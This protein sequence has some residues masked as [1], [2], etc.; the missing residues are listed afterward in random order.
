MKMKRIRVHLVFHYKDE[1]P[2]DIDITRQNP[3]AAQIGD[4]RNWIDKIISEEIDK[5]IE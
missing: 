2:Y 1:S 5:V 4:I 3:S